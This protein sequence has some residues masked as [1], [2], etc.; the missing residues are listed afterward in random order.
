MACTQDADCGDVAK[1]ACNTQLGKCVCLHNGWRRTTQDDSSQVTGSSV[2]DFNGDGAAEVVYNDECRFRVYDGL[3]GDVWVREPS[4]SRTR[5]EYPIVAD[6]DN[7]GNAEIVF[8]TTTESGFCSEQLTGQYNAG[9]EV[10]GDANDLWV[11]ARRIWNQHAYHVTNVTE[12]GRIPVFEPESWKAL[13]GRRYNTYRSNPRSFDVAPDLAALGVQI[14]SPDAACGQLSSLLDITVQ[15]SN[16]GDLRVGPGVVLSFHGTWANPPLQETL[17]G[18]GNVPLTATLQN[19]LEPG[20]SVLVTVHYDAASNSPKVVPNE[21]RVVV[22]D[23][24]KARECIETNN[25]LTAKV[26]PGSTMPDLRIEIGTISATT[27]PSPQIPT[28]VFNDGTE[29]A[30]NVVVRYYAGDPSAGGSVLH[31]ETIAGPIPAGGNVSITPAIAGFPK[32]LFILVYGVVDPDNKIAECNDGNNSDAA[33]Q[34][35]VCNSVQ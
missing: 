27:C 35:I 24:D 33:A 19:S 32:G 29:P 6:V 22:D 13:N 12:G 5:I 8:A 1:F 31:E 10:W 21:I 15:V 7:D 11:S 28:K 2:F 14:S 16:Q 3:S 20:D 26:D 18:P 23:G 9:L 17:L 4:E 25:E 30:S 34:K